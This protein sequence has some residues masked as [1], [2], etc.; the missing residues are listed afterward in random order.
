M[1]EQ[2]LRVLMLD[3]YWSA[4][5]AFIYR[6][7]ICPGIFCYLCGVAY[8]NDGDVVLEEYGVLSRSAADI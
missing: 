3:I 1:L 7:R 5:A 2:H 8:F 4:L 6:Y